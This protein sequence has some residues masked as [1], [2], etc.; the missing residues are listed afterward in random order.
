[1]GLYFRRSVRVGPLRF[2]FSKGGIGVSAGIPGLRVGTGPR[3]HYVH[4]GAHGIYYRASLPS[5]PSLPEHTR[6]PAGTAPGVSSDPA[7]PD[8]TVGPEVAIES[9]SVLAMT[10]ANAGE[11][12]QDLNHKQGKLAFAPIVA[13]AVALTG[14]WI[15]STTDS[16]PA[17][18]ALA[19][20]ALAWFGVH[21]WDALRTITV[22]MYDL[23][24]PSRES[25]EQLA[26]DVTALNSAK[27]LWHISTTAS[28][29]DRKYHAGA[30]D[31]L[32][33]SA[34]DVV[35]GLPKRVRC[36]IDVPSLGVGR[37]RLYFF[38]DRVLVFEPAAVGAVSYDTL[39]VT[40]STTQFIEENSVPPDAQVVGRTWRFVNK[41]GGPDR[42]FKENRE[43]PVCR[44]ETLHFGS[45]S[46]LNEL[47]HVSRVGAGEPLCL[48]L[49][50]AGLLSAKR[51]AEGPRSLYG[52]SSTVAAPRR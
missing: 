14:L 25:F 4:A 31:L 21:Q 8:G 15:S 12:L 9:G 30:S 2:N 42:R 18:L 6:P 10:D 46:G 47:L 43:L 36:N 5:S 24:G 35:T 22:I 16:F 34:T 38:P 28:V 49:R 48:A 37:Q 23:D 33:R 40:R 51:G 52:A 45:P 29:R 17:I 44:Y 41:S 3:G 39:S 7:M 20:G 1:M 50:R 32:K 13:G 11:L 27:G 19:I 26:A